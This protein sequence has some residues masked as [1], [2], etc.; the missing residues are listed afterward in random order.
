MSY[1]IVTDVVAV[2]IVLGV[3][4]MVHELG[5]FLAARWFQVRVEVFSL[6]FGKRLFGVK[7]GD[8]D[9]R[10]SILPLGGYV[11][12]AGE[13]P[14]ES[15]T[16]DPGEFLSKPK[17]QRFV[18][19][20]MGP[21]MN[22]VLA[23]VLLTGLYMVKYEKLAYQE[24]A[25]EIGYI[26]KGSA[27]AKA[28][29]Q[30][31]D[32]LVRV[33]GLVNPK[34]ESVE[35]RVLSSPNQPLEIEARRGGQ[36]IH[37]T[38]TPGTEPRNRVGVAGWAPYVPANIKSLERDYP[39]VKAGLRPG[40]QI[41]AVDGEPLTFGPRLPQIMQEIGDRSITLTV[42]RGAQTFSVRVT[43]VQGFV[44]SLGRNIWRIGIVM[45]DDMI[46]RRLSL[47]AAFQL[48]L[49]TNKRFALLIFEFLGKMLE[50]KMSPRSLE[51]PIGIAQLSGEAVR[52]GLAELIQLMAAI[53][54][55]LGII[56][57]FPIPVLDGGVILL[58]VVEGLMRRDLSLQVKE[59]IIQVGFVFLILIAALVIYND[60]IKTLPAR[61]N[62]L[63]P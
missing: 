30:P 58:L 28:G 51:G 3:M 38:V 44:A 10:V 55:N 63:F 1:V 47:P 62:Q 56:N 26:E 25:A 29:L 31:G 53:S 48:S 2:A 41:V 21:A 17:W 16:G 20:F 59:R 15:L 39:A 54:L 14:T 34:W 24:R 50:R 5:H 22:I 49:E 40:D 27:A 37:T 13:N 45:D 46:E 4:I 35:I 19:A 8:T 57:L 60:I 42:K 9:Y 43:P 36:I 33:G 23:V 18:I 52:Q 7:K 61:F 11:K 12:M 6:G 32:L